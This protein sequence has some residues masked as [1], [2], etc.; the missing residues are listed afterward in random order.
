MDWVVVVLVLVFAVR[1]AVRGAV[2][3][4]FSLLGL[5][6]GLWT[7]GLVSQWVGGHWQGARPAVVFWA[8]RW[9]VAVLSGLAV[10]SLFQWWGALIGGALR[11]TPLHWPDRVGGL[12]A[13]GLVGLMLAAV[14]TLAV[15]LLPWAPAF[16]RAARQG[17]VTRPLLHGGAWACGQ[18]HGLFPGGRWLEGRFREAEKLAGG[19]AERS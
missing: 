12:A 4:V 3:Q 1:G 5:I 2:V 16:G 13:G 6:A 19:E 18:V 15:V 17:R 10:A 14:M 9:L 8:L 11:Q 7:V